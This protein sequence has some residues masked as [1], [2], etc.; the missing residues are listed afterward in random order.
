MKNKLLL[1]IPLV[2]SVYSAHA[3][4]CGNLNISV[5]NKSG[6]T[7]ALRSSNLMNG[8]IIFGQVPGIVENGEKSL[9]FTLQQTYSA[10][11]SIRL[12]FECD[13]KTISIVSRQDLCVMYAGSVSGDH[14]SSN[15]I[16]ADYITK[17]GSWWNSLPGEINWT[18]G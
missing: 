1:A 13:N 9:S 15:N 18:I 10:G 17:I 14:T 4:N 7:C 6:H 3:N 2:A 8:Q 12:E 16:H 11:P 5:Y